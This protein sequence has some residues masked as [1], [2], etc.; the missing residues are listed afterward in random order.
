MWLA[1]AASASLKEKASRW[2]PFF[3]LQVLFRNADL[4]S[5]S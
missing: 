2:K 1:E 5:F 4:L 3:A